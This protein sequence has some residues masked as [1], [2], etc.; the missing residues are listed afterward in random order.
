MMS[1]FGLLCNRRLRAFVRV[2]STFQIGEVSSILHVND[3]TFFFFF[4]FFL[5][6]DLRGI[7]HTVGRRVASSDSEDAV[8]FSIP[9]FELPACA[10][11]S[12][13]SNQRAWKSISNVH[14]EIRCFGDDGYFVPAIKDLSKGGTK[15]NDTP[16]PKEKYYALPDRAEISLSGYRRKHLSLNSIDYRC[17]DGRK[18]GAI[19]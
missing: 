8:H 5:P 16:V 3:S 1:M 4:F 9:A 12:G 14:F 18:A 19:R 10:S 13:C 2:V 17:E 15:V 7:R 11:S 6:E